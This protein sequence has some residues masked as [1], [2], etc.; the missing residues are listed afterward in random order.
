MISRH[1]ADTCRNERFGAHAR[2]VDGWLDNS[3]VKQSMGDE[4]VD[5]R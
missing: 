5:L 2:S 4:V 1:E 3:S